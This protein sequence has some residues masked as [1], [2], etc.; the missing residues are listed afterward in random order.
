[1]SVD[2]LLAM[3]RKS[4]SAVMAT[5][6]PIEAERLDDT[7]YHGVSL[8]LP[9]FAVRLS[10]RTFMKVFHR[11]PDS[12]EL[13]G[14]NVRI[15]QDFGAPDQGVHGEYVPQTGRDGEPRTFGHY[16]VTAL[17]AYAP[18]R[19]VGAGLMIDYSLGHNPRLD[20]TSLLRD[21]IVAVH[22][23]SVDLLLGW[24]YL[25]L[26]AFRLGTPSYFALSRGG[27]LRHVVP[28]SG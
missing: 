22:P 10:W 18:P 20:P 27:P 24:S 11:D 3:D 25:D 8:G 26:G 6:H 14:W 15:V 28:S 17:D 23:G 5:G 16:R 12:G 4:L 13:R 21:P 9:G 19:T 2:R 1:M 7:E